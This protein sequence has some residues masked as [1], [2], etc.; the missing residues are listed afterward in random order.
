M[1]KFENKTTGVRKDEK[2]N[3][4][5]FADLAI[6][7]LNT[8]VD[9]LKVDDIRKRLTLLEKFETAVTTPNL[10]TIELEDEEVK[11]LKACVKD[12]DGRWA[13]IHRAIVEFNDYVAAL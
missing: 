12:M 3:M 13:G 8:Q 7:C 11:T 4:T 10:A 6:V 2:G 1:V 9:G 5:T